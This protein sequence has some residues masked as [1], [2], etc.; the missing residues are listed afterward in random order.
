MGFLRFFAERSF[1]AAM[2]SFLIVFL[3]GF[4][5]S[6]MKLQEF[7]DMELPMT[8]ISTSVNSAAASDIENGV[9]NRLEDELKS[10]SGIEYSTSTSKEGSSRIQIR[11]NESEDLDDVNS[12]IQSAVDRSN[13]ILD[14]EIPTVTPFSTGLFSVLSFG[15]YSDEATTDELQSYSRE[16]EKKIRK[17]STVS[18]VDVNGLRE[19]EF[20]VE[21]DPDKI[22]A[23][24]LDFNIISSKIQRRNIETSGGLLN[25]DGIEKRILTYSKINNVEDLG[26]TIIGIRNGGIN[27]RLKDVAI[28]KDTYEKKEASSFIG[29]KIGISFDVNKAS[30]ADIRDSINDVKTLL[31][32][33]ESAFAG[34]YKYEIGMDLSVDMGERFSIVIN[35]G[36]MGLFLVVCILSISL[37]KEVSFWVSVSIPFCVLGV[38]AFLPFFGISLDT[39]TLAALLLV[40]GIIVD[41]S[42]VVA[43]SISQYRQKGLSPVEASVEGVKDVFKP[44]VA[45]LT[46]TC[47]VFVPMLFLTGGLGMFV[48]VVP[49]VVIL[50]LLL[51]MI[52][53]FI[54]LPAH[55]KNIKAKTE[56]DNFEKIKVVYV[57]F[58]SK[59]VSHKYK[60]ILSSIAV[61][62]AVLYTGT[63]LKLDFF[64]TDDAKYMK[65]RVVAPTGTSID[66]I[67]KFNIG[68]VKSIKE[69]TGEDLKSIIL[70]NGTPRSSGMIELVNVSEREVSAE[71]YAQKY[72]GMSK[73]GY[74]VVVR[75]D[76]GAGPP[77]G[78]PVD[79]RIISGNDMKREEAIKNVIAFLESKDYITDIE[80]TDDVKNQQIR[81]IPDYEWIE[82]Y[83]YSV[84]ELSQLLR[85]AFDGKVSTSVWLGDDE[86]DIR[87][88]LDDESKKLENLIKTKIEMPNGEW[89]AIAQ[90][91]KIEE[92]TVVSELKHWNGERYTGVTA[93]ISNEEISS[94]Q[95][96]NQI[97]DAFA[98]DLFVKYEIGGQAED[99]QETAM[100][101][102]K[103]FVVSVIGMYF[104]LAL[105]L[106]SLIQPILIL[107]VLPYAFAG[108][109]GAVFLHGADLSFFGL[110]GLLGM[111][112]V[113][114]NNSLVLI[115]KANELKE[116]GKD[117]VTAVIEAAEN[118]LRPIILTSL[119]TIFCLLPLVYGV[120]GKDAFM[121]P[122]AMTL[123]YGLL[124]TIP[125]VLFVIPCYYLMV[126]K[127]KKVN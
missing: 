47:L 71:E 112:G 51:S 73:D 106:N 36:L 121:S 64:P 68:I 28:I 114:V 18:S 25:D 40:I 42:V 29:E 48:F 39:I 56:K 80:T 104:V 5:L 97:K 92:V 102:V 107:T 3:G 61:T 77:K 55:I 70:N 103:A 1:F 100:E 17:L 84:Q 65:V 109:I 85:F 19:R 33:E 15:V 59:V 43:E 58:L 9:T 53:C 63:L 10:V 72:R 78:E 54:L 37:R 62:C 50:S 11:I 14:G 12:D 32:K 30:S 110:I 82:K 123:G 23:Y 57:R 99:T 27:V 35:N 111:F 118:R 122:M 8:F 49:V 93:D 44:L 101:L 60:V 79:V 52:D 116:S 124:L 127:E 6:G 81:V 69:K 75:V 98:D 13:D 95:V 34:K 4:V 108:A 90:L 125:I 113:V 66:E 24:K 38:I 45:S 41:D 2:M 94:I 119:T 22:K 105:L 89:V 120:G 31:E 46:T 76:G 86:V 88:Q 74:R 96:S 7:P 67:E 26:E 20:I 115:N 16:L 83:N 126:T 117:N 91:V 21:L 87:L